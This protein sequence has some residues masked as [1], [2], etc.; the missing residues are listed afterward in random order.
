MQSFV[1]SYARVIVSIGLDL[2][3]GQELLL[4]TPVEA[5]ELAAA[6]AREAYAAGAKYVTVRYFDTA[7]D[8][9][10]LELSDPSDLEYLPPEYGADRLRIAKEGDAVAVFLGDDPEALAGVDSERIAAA[11]RPRSARMRPAMELL[12]KDHH[13]WCVISAPTQIWAS[14][15]F[16][17]LAPEAALEKL[18][19]SVS[20]A[21]RL[22]QP[23]PVVAW[24]SHANR[25]G[26]IANYLTSRQFDRFQYNGPGT[27]LSVGMPANHVWVGTEGHSSKGNTFIANLPTDETFCAPDW[28]RVEGTLR[29]TRPSIMSGTNVGHVSLT[30]KDGKIVDF[31]AE[32]N[33]DVVRAELDLDEQARSFGEIALVAESSPV[34][35]MKTVFYDGLYDENAGCHLAFGNAYSTNVKGGE[36]MSGDELLEAGLNQSLQ[37]FDFT[38]GSPELDITAFARDGSQFPVIVKGEWSEQLLTVSGAADG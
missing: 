12:M 15:V 28:R 2:R 13:N 30:V 34:A 14:R 27:D 20:R 9:A 8:R 18:I 7:V 11:R 24:K 6:V 1:E 4:V 17:D 35:Q 21:C 5:A 22:D 23:D 10:R 3:K 36:T 37:H 25:L 33:E 19:G 16:P 31:T 29:G 32:Q 26:K 38:V